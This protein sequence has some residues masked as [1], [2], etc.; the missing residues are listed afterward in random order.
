MLYKFKSKAGADVIM[1]AAHGDQALE[2]LGRSASPQGIFQ[3]AELPALIARGEAAIAQ[4][5][6]VLDRAAEEARA[7]G[8]KPPPRPEVML[9]Q[10]L[11]PLLELMRASQAAD[12]DVVWG[13]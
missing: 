2:A 7:D 10:R 11:W 6:E 4:E 3:K 12:A 13:V 8:R 1:L 9:R 5:Q